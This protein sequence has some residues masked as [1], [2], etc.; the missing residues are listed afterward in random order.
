MAKQTIEI[1]LYMSELVYDV[2]Q[3]A[4]LIG[5]A[6]RTDETSE[7]AAKVQD[8]TDERKDAILRSFAESYACLRNELSEYLVETNRYAD[9]ILLQE[10][11]NKIKHALVFGYQ[12][13]PAAQSEEKEDNTL[14]LMLRVPMNFNLSVRGDIAHAMHNYMTDRAVAT[15]LLL[16]PA[17]AEAETYIKSAQAALL[18]LHTAINKRIRPTR[19]HAPEQ[20]P[21]QQNELRY[22]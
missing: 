3:K 10:E 19:V 5:D 6:M 18:E 13:K 9:N 16:T 17:K 21:P 8:L 14:F 15:W 22:E 12:G 11:R 4:H 7:Q 2:Q 1:K 20:T